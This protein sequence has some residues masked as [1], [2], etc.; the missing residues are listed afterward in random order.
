[1]RPPDEIFFSIIQN[2]VISPDD[3]PSAEKLSAL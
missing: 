3:F 1:M 2:K